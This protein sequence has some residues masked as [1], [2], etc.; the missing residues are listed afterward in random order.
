MEERIEQSNSKAKGISFTLIKGL[1][2]VLILSF[3]H[4]YVGVNFRSKILLGPMS[5]RHGLFDRIRLVARGKS[6]VS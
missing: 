1:Q 2:L 4:G 6:K 3:K 5:V